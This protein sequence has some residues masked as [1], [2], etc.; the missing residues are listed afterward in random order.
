MGPIV[1]V[2]MARILRG[3]KT[4]NH[5]PRS[6]LTI[7]L[8]SLVRFFSLLESHQR[9]RLQFK[10]LHFCSET[11]CFIALIIFG[12]FH[13]NKGWMFFFPLFFCFA[14]FL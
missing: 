1:P 3:T 2:S 11:T 6:V 5:S 7:C 13:L 12:F 9:H 10:S 4:G 14:N 8:V